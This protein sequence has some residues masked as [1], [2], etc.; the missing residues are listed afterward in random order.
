MAET[1]WRDAMTEEAGGVP[2]MEP[3]TSEADERQLELAREQGAAYERALAHMTEDVADTGGDAECG[4]YRV[5]YAIE[6]AEG[7][8]EW[9]DG[10]LVWR[11]PDEGGIH[12][13][14]S[15]RDAADRR[16]VPGVRV[17]AT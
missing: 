13:E 2:P 12:V 5:G 1:N 14:I 7:I 8:Y 9:Q 4:H 17:L 16:F 10:G 6:E 11:Q 3:D 15:V